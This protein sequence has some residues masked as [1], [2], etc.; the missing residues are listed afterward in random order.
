[1][2]SNSFSHTIIDPIAEKKS[3]VF[4][5]E[6]KKADTSWNRDRF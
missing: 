1:M 3:S 4:I 2:D 6:L 5:F